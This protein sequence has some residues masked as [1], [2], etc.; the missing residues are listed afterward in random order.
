MN[1]DSA[2]VALSASLNEEGP[3]VEILPGTTNNEYVVNPVA[4]AELEGLEGI[5][6]VVRTSGS[7]GTP[8]RTA[9]SIDALA[10]SSMATAEYLGFEGQWLL[11]LPIHFVAGLA[12]L[13][14]SLYAGT[15]PWAMDLE[16]SFT[17][18]G[19]NEA[20]SALT[21]RKRL[22]SLVP[23]QLQRLL[24]DPDAETIST[25]QRFDAILL[26][27]ARAPR[28]VLKEA[29]RHSLKLHLTYGSSETAGGCVYDARALPGVQV[30]VVDGR[31]MLGGP[32]IASGYLGDAGLTAR[33]FS[34]DGSGVR[35]YATD[36]LGSYADGMLSVSGRADDVIITGGVKVS[37]AQ[38]QRVLEALPGVS[39]AA[40]V[41]VPDAQWGQQIAAA[42]VGSAAP[43]AL[44]AAVRASLGAAAVPRRLQALEALPLLPN[45]KVDRMSLA[46]W[47]AETPR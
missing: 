10:S 36:D 18:R 39:E 43:E 15:R 28:A 27:G 34:V 1:P 31:I 32:T 38:V 45:G 35:W 40:V 21:D 42:Y 8:K 4:G 12:V 44:S 47:L 6:A 17:A 33:H 11:P 3:A 20:A 7:T 9:L 24:E 23:T 37:A 26:G 19:F 29:A 13:T 2:L 22:V 16:Q 14:R 41:P 46:A 5:A 25:L 30:K